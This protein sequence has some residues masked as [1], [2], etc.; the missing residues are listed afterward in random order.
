MARTRDTAGALEFQVRHDVRN[1]PLREI[2]HDGQRR[3][4]GA[5]VVVMAVLGLLLASAAVR[6]QQIH[7]GY[8]IEDLQAKRGRLEAERRHLL[9]EKE[10]LQALDRIDRLATDLLRLVKPTA[11][12]AYVLERVKAA[13]EPSGAV[14][15]RR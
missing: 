3:M 11:A 2:D 9:A 6:L 13:P 12:D 8:R 5:T 15:A 10:S 4:W 7:L 14:V 1:R